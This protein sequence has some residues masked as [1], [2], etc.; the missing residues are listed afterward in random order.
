MLGGAVQQLSLDGDG[1]E[2]SIASIEV[3]P[4][5]DKLRKEPKIAP[6]NRNIGKGKQYKDMTAF[7]DDVAAWQA[8][9]AARAAKI[10][11]RERVQQQWIMPGFDQGIQMGPV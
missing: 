5:P 6:G 9:K 10:K 3:P 1:E 8:E 2:S 7:T 4:L 11:E